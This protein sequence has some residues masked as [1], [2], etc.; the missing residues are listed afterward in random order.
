MEATLN[1]PA[2]AVFV[3]RTVQAQLELAEVSTVLRSA[4]T[5]ELAEALEELAYE[6]GGNLAG[7]AA[8]LLNMDEAERFEVLAMDQDD[9]RSYFA[10]KYGMAA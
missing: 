9:E 10:A 7:A 2:A 4:S 6:L 8:A 5:K 1:Q 3:A